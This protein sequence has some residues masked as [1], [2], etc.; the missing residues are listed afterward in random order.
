MKIGKARDPEQRL[1][2]LQT[3]CPYQLKIIAKIKCRSDRHALEVER[4][5]HKYFDRYRMRGEW[6]KCSD[7]VVMKAWEFERA[8]DCIESMQ[9][10]PL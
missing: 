1:R 9:E 4:L 6:F 8:S 7:F 5:A 10:K 3:G 2:D